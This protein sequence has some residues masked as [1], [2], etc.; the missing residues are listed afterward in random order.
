MTSMLSQIHSEVEVRHLDRSVVVSAAHTFNHFPLHTQRVSE[1]NFTQPFELDISQN[2]DALDAFVIWFDTFFLPSRDD[3]VDR[4]G[5]IHALSGR[6]V[7]F[8]TGPFSKETHWRQSVLLIDNEKSVPRCC[9]Q[10]ERV[11]GSITYKT[12][13]ESPR[14]LDI[15]IE[16]SVLST[17]PTPSLVDGPRKQ[18]W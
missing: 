16:W 18:L 2:I 10:G 5:R 9:Y 11:K 4:N 15:E 14:A 6:P 17:G 12:P 7:E 3:I 1:L 8:T 13:E